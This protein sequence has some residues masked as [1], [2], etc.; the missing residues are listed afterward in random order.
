MESV[1]G[2]PRNALTTSPAG[3]LPV[4]LRWLPLAQEWATI[5][6]NIE[7]KSLITGQAYI[8]K[9][10]F[11]HFNARN[12]NLFLRRC[13]VFPDRYKFLPNFKKVRSTNNQTSCELRVSSLRTLRF[14]AHFASYSWIFL[15]AEDAENPQRTQRDNRTQTTF[16]F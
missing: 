16:I 2:M 9:L 4:K 1:A 5:I 7:I 3:V 10:L 6:T 12:A 8:T 14:F 11:H 15:D 13:W